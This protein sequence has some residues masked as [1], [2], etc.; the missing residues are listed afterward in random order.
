MMESIWDTDVGLPEFPALEGD[1]RTDVLIVGGGLAGLLCAWKLTRAGVDC[2]LIEQDRIMGGVSGRTTA[3]LT[4]QHGLIYHRLLNT[5]GPERARMY[6]RANEEALS[7][8]KRL[9]GAA[10]FDFVPENNWIYATDG[11]E[12]LEAEMT[13]CEKLG[14]PAQWGTVLPLPFPVAGAVGFPGQARI[15]PLKLA[16]C[17]AR[18]LPI[19]ENTKALEFLGNQVRTPRGTVTAEKVIVATHFPM[20]NKHGGYFLKLYQQR[21]YVLALENAPRIRQCH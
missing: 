14:I 20:L 10:D 12:K 13:A 15:H 6:W 16:A 7:E 5:F 2:M 18:G 9:A 17:L 1:R 19:Y 4:S 3:K 11:T 8:Y 21:S